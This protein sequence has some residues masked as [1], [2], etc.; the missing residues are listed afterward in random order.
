L[1]DTLHVAIS[2]P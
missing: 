2:K 1:P